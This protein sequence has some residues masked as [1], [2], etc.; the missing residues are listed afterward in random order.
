MMVQ[1]RIIVLFMLHI[2]E[3][4]IN[5]NNRFGSWTYCI[6]D[7]KKGKARKR[8]NVKWVDKIPSC[9]RNIQYEYT[10]TNV[11][12]CLCRAGRIPA[13]TCMSCVS[14]HLYLTFNFCE[15]NQCLRP[16]LHVDVRVLFF[17]FVF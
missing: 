11:C 16:Y 7:V 1:G 10:C 12:L 5:V 15:K 6:F 14:V 9:L 13:Y 4:N 3:V 2:C 17:L 8:M